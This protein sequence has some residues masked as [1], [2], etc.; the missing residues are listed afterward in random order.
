MKTKKV[1]LLLNG[2]TPNT[3]PNTSIYDVV[4]ATDGAYQYLKENNIK[5]DFITGDFDSLETIPNNV[6]VIHTPNQDLTDFDKILQILFDQDFYQIDIYG[7]SG[8]EQD[9]FLGNLHTAIQWKNKLK[10][11]FL[12]NY[13]SYFLADKSTIITDCRNKVVS[14]VPFPSV[15]KITTE[16]L[17]YQLNDE[18]LVFG[19]RIG[20][21]NKA[22]ENKIKITFESGNLF[23]FINEQNNE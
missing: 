11:T 19:K 14:L 22:K 9:H 18:D 3:V 16:G 1:F 13:G 8:N 10:L 20:T 6:K 7:A 2:T 17:Q 21:R 5:P 12:D 23:L 15:E 4:C